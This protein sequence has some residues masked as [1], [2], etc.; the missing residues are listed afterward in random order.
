MTAV[1]LRTSEVC[2]FAETNCSYRRGVR[3]RY[4]GG[5]FLSVTEQLLFW[6]KKTY[7][8]LLIDPDIGIRSLRRRRF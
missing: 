2:K 4:C 3:T 6:Q 7:R 8:L 1:V 5:S